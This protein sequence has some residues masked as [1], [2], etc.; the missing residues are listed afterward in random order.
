LNI[1]G[2][3]KENSTPFLHG[4]FLWFVCSF[5]APRGLCATSFAQSGLLSWKL[6]V[7]WYS[8]GLLFE[9]LAHLK[10]MGVILSAARYT[11]FDHLQTAD[12]EKKLEALRGRSWCLCYY[13]VTSEYLDRCGGNL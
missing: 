7:Y 5:G 13:C 8:P 2:A 9:V 12:E 1:F 3:L 6:P 4:L 11:R 10:T